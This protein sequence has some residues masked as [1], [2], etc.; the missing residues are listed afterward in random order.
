MF[1]KTLSPCFAK[2]EY[3]SFAVRGVWMSA[4]VDG[5][6]LSAIDSTLLTDSVI[7]N[8]LLGHESV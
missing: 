1:I 8:S 6:L 5:L 4:W 2:L 3:L 7:V